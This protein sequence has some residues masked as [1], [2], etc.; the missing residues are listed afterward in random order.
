MSAARGKNIV[1]KKIEEIYDRHFDMVYRISLSYL[2]NTADAEDAAADVFARLL[3][4]EVVFQNIEHEKARLIRTTVNVCKD[5]LKHW[6]NRRAALHEQARQ[7]SSTEYQDNEVW[8][9]IIELPP[10][11]KDVIYLYYYEGYTTHELAGI[12][13]KPHSTVRSQLREARER[14]KEVLGDEE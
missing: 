9:A 12:L 13:K 8:M 5:R 4:K 11:Y 1:H 10:Q 6:W 2:K 14:L 3:C 7:T